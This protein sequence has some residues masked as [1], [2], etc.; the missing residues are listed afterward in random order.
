MRKKIAGIITICSLAVSLAGA[1]GIK[2]HH[3]AWAEVKAA[4]EKEHK[5]I[6][7]DFYTTWCAPCKFMQN[8]VFPLKQIGD[9]YNPRFISVKIDAEKGEGPALAKKYGVAGY[10]TLIFTNPKEEVVYRVMGSADPEVLITQGKIATTPMAD[11]NRMTARYEKNE[12]NR[13]ELF[14]YLNLV[15]AKGDDKKAATVFESY[16]KLV[17]HAVT[18]NLFKLITSYVGNSDNAAFRFVEEN[19]EAFETAMGKEKVAAY[20]DKTLLAEVMYAHYNSEAEYQAAKMLLKSRLILSEKEE[21]DLDA[22]HCYEMKDEAGYMKY[23]KLLVE[24]YY[25]NNDF[26]LSNVLGSI[27]WVKE[28][29]HLLVMKQWAERALLLKDNS[30][31]NTSLA[32]VYNALKDKKNAMKYIE[33]AI[34]ASERDKDGYANNIAMIKKQITDNE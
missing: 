17:D 32:M 31:N 20:V 29:K 4:A 12:L 19:R 25:W 22:N 16:F 28:D 27:R 14:Q 1:Q 8:E 7:V 2:F 15:K 33:A 34:A 6:F 9:F 13:E 30:L 26:E 23:S 5:L 18:P 10:P 11:F 24:R 3:G 21:L